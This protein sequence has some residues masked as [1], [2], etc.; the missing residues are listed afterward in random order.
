[1]AVLQSSGYF[2]KVNRKRDRRDQGIQ[3]F[4]LES[5][6]APNDKHQ[7]DILISKAWFSLQHLYRQEG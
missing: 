7:Y 3:E 5:I 1:M 6:N 2:D 4:H